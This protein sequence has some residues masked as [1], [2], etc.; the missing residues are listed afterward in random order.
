[1]QTIRTRLRPI[2]RDGLLAF[3]EKGRQNPTALGT[4]RVRT[5]TEGQYRTLSY[6]GEHAPVVVDEPLHLLGE[7]T[8]PAPGEIVL[9]GLGGCLAVGITALA[10]WKQVPLTRL[11]ILW[12]GDIG[13][14]AAWGAGGALEKTPEQVGFQGIRVQVLIEATLDRSAYR[15]FLFIAM[16][17]LSLLLVAVAGAFLSV[18]SATQASAAS[19][20]SFSFTTNRTASPPPAGSS[21]LND[22]TRDIRL[23]SV[24]AANGTTYSV[25][26]VVNG[27][28]ILQ[29]DTYTAAN[30]Q[31]YGLLNSGRGGNT[32][33]DPLVGEGPSKPVE[34]A[35]D[36]VG[37]LGNLNLNSLVVTRESAS[38]ASFEVS[39]ANPI[40]KIFFWERGG[41]AGSSTY[42]DSDL[43][44][45]ALDD[46]GSVIASCKILRQN[47]TPANYNI[48]TVVTPILNNGLFNIGSIGLSLDGATTRSL[49][50]TSADNNKGPI[51]GIPPY[52]G[53][54]GPDFKLVATPGPLPILAG[55]SALAWSR[56]VRRRVLAAQ[57]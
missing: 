10:T 46:V 54:N 57:R 19:F 28:K 27:A 31:T 43:L 14:A 42:G 39:F 50:L 23:D 52:S 35:A 22:P 21:L 40:D 45:E 15:C 5:V 1:V 20:S 8:A 2:S 25:F 48:S 32:P 17:R 7:N 3:A 4:N 18:L 13:N 44:V 47:Y 51:G 53:D 37:S 56:K 36:I 55:V 29:N 33:S 12:E 26:E 49:R 9:A 11:E 24:T 16:P 30:G 6:V 38:T 41:S 34:T